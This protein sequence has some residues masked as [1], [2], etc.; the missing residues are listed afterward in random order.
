MQGN[1]TVN[2]GMQHAVHA[3]SAAALAFFGYVI[4]DL[5]EPLCIPALCCLQ[6]MTMSDHETMRGL[7]IAL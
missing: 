6:C 5:T 2:A 3:G 4:H 7:Q 1:A